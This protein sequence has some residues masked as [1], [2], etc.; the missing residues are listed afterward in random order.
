MNKAYGFLSYFS[1]KNP[2]T[3][4]HAIAIV[5]TFVKILFFI[6]K[7]LA[8]LLRDFYIFYFIIVAVV[9]L[10]PFYYNIFM[11]NTPYSQ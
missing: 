8:F 6:L 5:I 4:A 10:E 11:V 7:V 9:C 2:T 1:D 3:R